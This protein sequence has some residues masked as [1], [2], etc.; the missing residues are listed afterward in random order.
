MS[1]PEWGIKRVCPSCS[2]KYYDFNKD[3]II[4]PKCEFK[5]DPD[6]L[7]K[8]RKG[9]S[10][11]AKIEDNSIDYI[12]SHSVMEH[13]RKYELDSLIR[14]MFRVLKPNGVISHN[15]NYKDHLGESLNNLRFSEK[16]WESNLFANSGFYTNRV[17]ALEM[18]NLFKRNGPLSTSI[19]PIAGNLNKPGTVIRGR[20]GDILRIFDHKSGK[21][22]K[23]K[24]IKK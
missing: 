8:S 22:I 5:F 21:F 18:H 11:A 1:K 13:I 2:I 10:I 12:F 7:L 20:T 14:E 15:I 17:P 23:I 16:L 6:L 19:D 9:R 3:P 24:E 4:C